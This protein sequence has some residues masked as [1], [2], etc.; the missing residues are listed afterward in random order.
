[1]MSRKKP[2]GVQLKAPDLFVFPRQ[3]ALCYI[4]RLKLR[5]SL[6][7]EEIYLD[8]NA[9]TPV[10]PEVIAVMADTAERYW[11]NPSSGHRLGREAAEAL[12]T[13][14]GAIARF[15]GADP[16]EI[17]FTAG[18]T[19]A[20]NLAVIGAARANR[21]RGKHILVSSVEHHAILESCEQLEKE[22]FEIGRLPVD[23]RGLVNPDDVSRDIRGDTILISVMHANN[24]V[25]TIEPVAEI[26]RIAGERGVLFHTDAAQTVGKIPVDVNRLHVDLLTCASHKIY[27]PKGI[28]FLYAR[29]GTPL[30]PLLV[31]G[32][33][34]KHRR[35][36]TEN[37]PAVAGLARAL[38]IAETRME[39]EGDSL[40]K[41]RDGLYKR[42][43]EGLD[44]V[45]L[46][47]HPTE[48][49]PGT[50][51]VSVAGIS[52]A[53][54]LVRLDGEGIFLSA[55][56]ACT[57]ERVR[58]SH[59]L[60]AM[61]IGNRQA[62]TTLRISLGRATEEHHIPQVADAIITTVHQLRKDAT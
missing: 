35:S 60:T 15:V 14:R 29:A 52:A 30:D 3:D 37:I 23:E 24:E 45:T 25:G 18:G 22:G 46:N 11:A 17:I 38:M 5:E 12:A 10:D 2:A 13:N 33:Q 48:R 4:C 57:T 31:G 59:V 61:G 44:G 6:R 41:L 7:M 50:L 42:L 27:G 56:A 58:P 53:E 62:A 43:T 32:G 36:G 19:E 9:T 47:G 54:L 55:S 40:R 51:N 16:D 1:M 49:L 28:G 26:G 39:T 34:E 8:Y 20:D 21:D